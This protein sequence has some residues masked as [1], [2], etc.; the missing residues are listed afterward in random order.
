MT[1]GAEQAAPHT[2]PRLRDSETRAALRGR[3]LHP[4]RRL[5]FYSFGHGSFVDRPVWLAGV[6][7]ISIGNGTVVLRN[8]SLATSA[9]TWHREGAAFVIGVNVTVNPH[10]AFSVTSSLTLEDEV[11]VGAYSM[12]VDSLHRL[13]GP[14][15]CYGRNPSV[16]APIRVGRG[17]R[18]GERV[19]ILRGTNVG[20]ECVIG[21]NSVV[22]GRIPDYS[23]VAGNPARIVGSTRPA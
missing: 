19:S 13:D 10:C 17:T 5:R 22:Q 18:V 9:A 15:E 16:A 23:I 12:M 14:N 4:Y 2:S 3:L 21:T 1:A 11:S 6:H 20:R 7:K 8:C